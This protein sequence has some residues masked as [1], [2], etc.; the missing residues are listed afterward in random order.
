MYCYMCDRPAIECICA[1]DDRVETT[2]PPQKADEF[3]HSF[4]EILAREL[5][6]L[7][8]E[9][10]FLVA[11]KCAKLLAATRADE[12]DDSE[13]MYFYKLF[14][15]YTFYDVD[16]VPFRPPLESI[17]NSAKTIID[18]NEE[19]D[20]KREFDRYKLTPEQE[21]QNEILIANISAERSCEL[22]QLWLERIKEDFRKHDKHDIVL[23]IRHKMF[24]V[25]KLP[26]PL[27]EEIGEIE[28]F[29]MDFLDGDESF[30]F[31][32]D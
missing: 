29:A 30:G 12:F 15:I 28:D 10:V 18:T 32:E 7:D 27:Q 1:E 5:P 17:D 6:T 9:K 22:A 31:I 11:K 16:H 4:Y 3:V 23:C 20:I 13:E 2:S 14:W 24:D 8:V 19:F 25:R 21:R 26:K